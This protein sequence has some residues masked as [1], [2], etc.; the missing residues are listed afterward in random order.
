MRTSLPIILLLALGCSEGSRPSRSSGKSAPAVSIRIVEDGTIEVRGLDGPT[1]RQLEAGPIEEEVAAKL[2]V[3]RVGD[4]Q[5]LPPVLGGIG[6]EDGRVL[7]EPT[8]PFRPG[9]GYTV[10]WSPAA[11]GG[12]VAEDP[13]VTKVVEIPAPE[14]KPTTVVERVDPPG[15]VLPEN[16]LRV[17]VYFSAPMSRGRSYRHL[18]LVDENGDEVE[19]GFL[20][21]GEELWDGEGRRF[22]LLF[23]PG[24]IKRELRPREELGPALAD[25]GKYT[26]VVDADWKDAKGVSLVEAYRR[27]FRVG[28]PDTTPPAVE[29]WTIE[30]PAADSEAAL[31]VRFDESLDRAMLARMITVAS[32]PGKAVPGEVTVADDGKSWEFLPDEMWETGDYELVVDGRLEDLAGNGIGRPFEVRIDGEPPEE[33]RDIPFARRAF[34][35]EKQ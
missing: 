8:F 33:N 30:P 2:L 23:D 14:V 26:L 13:V 6:Y 27:S 32:T 21:L 16:L 12:A 20:E 22:T 9:V 34:R 5:T 31:V 24:R 17:Y 19:E 7:F 10:R 1:I 35:I 15:E 3:V 11:L 29:R 25:G 28:P 4:D 18:H